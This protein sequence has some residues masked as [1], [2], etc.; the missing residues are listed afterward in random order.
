MENHG[1]IQERVH[2]PYSMLLR[3]HGTL[4]GN[5]SIWPRCNRP[6]NDD[7]L[8]LLHACHSLHTA[9]ES[10]LQIKSVRV[11][12]KRDPFSPINRQGPSPP[13]AINPSYDPHSGS[14]GSGGGGSHVG[15]TIFGTLLFML[16]AGGGVLYAL[17]LKM[18]GWPWATTN[19]ANQGAYAS[20][21]QF[22]SSESTSYQGK[23]LSIKDPFLS[24]LLFLESLISVFS[25]LSICNTRCCA[26]TW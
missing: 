21:H 22:S 4:H 2:L 10:A 20:V 18:G 1:V 23:I 24:F 26:C 25:F 13:S 12:Q 3:I 14:G 16:L 19:N 9:K 7:H 15:R 17:Y 6:V 8:L 11:W 5:V